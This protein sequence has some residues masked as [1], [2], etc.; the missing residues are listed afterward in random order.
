MDSQLTHNHMIP[1]LFVHNVV[2]TIQLESDYIDI[3]RLGQTLPYTNYDR[4]KFAAIT[5][6]LSDP[7]CT[8]L[9]FTSGKLVVTGASSWTEGLLTAYCIRDILAKVFNGK[10]FNVISYDVQN[11]VAHVEIG[12]SL[13]LESMYNDNSRE[14]TFQRNLFPGLIYRPLDQ[15]IVLLCFKSGKVVITGGKSLTH[16]KGQWTLAWENVKN[17]IVK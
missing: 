11:I 10:V 14:A 1:E 12:H 7:V 5:I 13:D 6:R 4:N 15:N 9:L 2:A 16:I 3:E 17:Y 8:C